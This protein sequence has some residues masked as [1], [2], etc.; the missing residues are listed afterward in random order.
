MFVT[1]DKVSFNNCST[2]ISWTDYLSKIWNK[3]KAIIIALNLFQISNYS[4]K[5]GKQILAI[6]K[7]ITTRILNGTSI[8]PISE[9]C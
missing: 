5:M 6:F 1:A 2:V 9:F 4:V 3:F 7:Y 8:V